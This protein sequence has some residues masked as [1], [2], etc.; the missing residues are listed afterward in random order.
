MAWDL[1]VANFD[2]RSEPVGPRLTPQ[3]VLK[4]LNWNLQLLV[5]SCDGRH[6]RGAQSEL[7][8]KIA[9]AKGEA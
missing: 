3:K 9:E 5:E 6:A 7:Q 8:R 2:C 4:D 1:A